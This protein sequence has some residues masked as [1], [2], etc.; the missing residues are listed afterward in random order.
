MQNKFWGSTATLIIGCLSFAAGLAQIS[1]HE[2]GNR[3][4]GTL[5]AGW[6]MILG[7]LAYKSLKKRKLGIKPDTLVRRLIE[8][9]LLVLAFLSV[10]LQANFIALCYYDPVP[11]VFIPACV[12]IAYAVVALRARQNATGRSS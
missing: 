2:S 7:A 3:S 9:L 12:F 11:N 10:V 4:G 1:S 8:A 5:I 6:V